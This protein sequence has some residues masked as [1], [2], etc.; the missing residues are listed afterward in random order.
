[1]EGCNGRK[2]GRSL[3]AL[4]LEEIFR[5][6]VVAKAQY[7]IDHNTGKLKY[8]KLKEISEYFG[9]SRST[10]QRLL[11]SYEKQE[12]SKTSLVDLSSNRVGRC[13]RPSKLTK[14]LRN[15]IA[16][17]NKQSGCLLPIRSLA[18][19]IK[20]LY[21]TNHWSPRNNFLFP[22]NP[23]SPSSIFITRSI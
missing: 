11:I 9:V 21:G 1:M 15:R 2:R 13:G 6:R 4:D 20:S 10:I 5:W 19:R 8:G 23:R 18:C 22:R 7:F 16:N 14:T 12:I 17:A 3:E